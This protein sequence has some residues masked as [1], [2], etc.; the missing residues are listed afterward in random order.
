MQRT[1]IAVTRRLSPATCCCV[2]LNVTVIGGESPNAT[3]LLVA[4]PQPRANYV[5]TLCESS[6]PFYTQLLPQHE[7]DMIKLVLPMQAT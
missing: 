6:G 7:E 2:R 5:D 3:P 1:K 4:Q